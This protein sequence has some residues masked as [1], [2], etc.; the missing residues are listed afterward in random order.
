M[1]LTA[2]SYL[3]YRSQNKAF[4]SMLSVLLV[5]GMFGFVKEAQAVATPTF[6]ISTSSGHQHLGS[7]YNTIRNDENNIAVKIN[8]V[9]D[10][11]CGIRFINCDELLPGDEC[12]VN[13]SCSD[14]T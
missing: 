9:A 5:A 2:G 4:R 6:T 12:H 8:I 7:L 13:F 3:L 10:P 11:N 1:F 14:E